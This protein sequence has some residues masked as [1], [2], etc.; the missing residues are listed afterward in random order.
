MNG[1]RRMGALR[2]IAV[3][4]AAC[5]LCAPVAAGAA[6]ARAALQVALRARGLYTGAVDGVRGPGTAGA[7]RALPGR[8]R[9]RGRRG[10]RAADA[11][12]ARLRAGGR[13]SGRRVLRERP[14]R[15]GRRGAAVP[16]RRQRVPV[17]RDRRRPRAAHA[18]R[19]CAASR[20]GRGSPPTA[21]AGPGDA[22]GAA[23]RPPPTAPLR[24]AA[25]G[26]RARRRPLRP[27]RRRV[28]HRGRLRGGRR[29]RRCPPPAAAASTCA[30]WDSGGYGN[31]VVVRHRLG[32]TSWYAHLS[33][34]RRRAG[35][36]RGRRATGS[37]AS[38]RPAARPARTCTS[39]CACAAPRSIR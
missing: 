25:A 29:R 32:M 1:V 10:R 19:R 11:A 39:R 33:R 7:V 35:T 36:V 26:R 38:A 30:G 22:R 4:L 8:A 14:P 37:A 24:F 16:A 9:A 3:A 23:R 17:G 6:R 20:P 5:A 15:L 18:T 2:C 21:L 27:A 13:R 12:R 31:L 28:P 34:D